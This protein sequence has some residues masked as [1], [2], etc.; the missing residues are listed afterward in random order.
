MP[1][2]AL[3]LARF[4]LPLALAAWVSLVAAGDLVEAAVA[5]PAILLL[6]DTVGRSRRLGGERAEGWP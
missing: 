1:E 2:L 5:S 4:T 3:T 6:A